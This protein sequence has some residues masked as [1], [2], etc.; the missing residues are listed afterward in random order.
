[1]S[2]AVK[3]PRNELWLFVSAMLVVLVAILPPHTAY[4]E[5][6]IGGTTLSVEETRAALTDVEK[7]SR[8]HLLGSI[9]DEALP[10]VL[11][12]PTKEFDKEFCDEGKS[13]RLLGVR[14]HAMPNTLFV[15]D[16]APF[17]PGSIKAVI[18]HELTHWV[19]GLTAELG[20]DNYSCAHR[21][22]REIEAYT[23]GY[24]YDYLVEGRAYPFIV[25]DIY[26]D[27]VFS[28]RP[29]Q[30]PAE[31]EPVGV[32]GDPVIVPETP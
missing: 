9:P 21:A 6:S 19:Q 14:F 13:C 5:E 24:L 20:D 10:L 18:R 22:A 1:M 16:Y 4:A 3:P 2:Y 11:I 28:A 8:Y 29:T 15:R 7:F 30:A 31:G 32:T 27:C 12:V 25:P 17:F 26:S 23:V